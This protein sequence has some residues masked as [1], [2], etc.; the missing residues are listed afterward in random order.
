MTQ[1]IPNGKQQFTDNNG[2]PLLGGKV[3]F[4]QVGTQTPKNT[5]QDSAE[6]ILNTNPVTLDAR[7]SA[8][9][10]GTGPY[11]QVVRDMF[12]SLIWDQIIPDAAGSFI[13]D[14]G[15]HNDPNKGA[16]LI[17]R[18][19]RQ[20]FS[21]SELMTIPGRYH[22]DQI[23]LSSY[24]SSWAVPP[25]A[26]PLGAG[27]MVWDENSAETPDLG[28]VFQ[29]GSM[30]LGR[31]KRKAEEYVDVDYGI[32]GDGTDETLAWNR[33][34]SSIPDGASV[35]ITR[36]SKVGNLLCSKNSISL[37]ARSS[38]YIESPALISASASVSPLLLIGG[39]GWSISN[40]LFEDQSAASGSVNIGS[41]AV[42][43]LRSDLSRD[44]DSRINGC[45]FSSFD[46]GVHAVGI[47]LLALEN[48][49][50]LCLRPILV[51]QVGSE[52]VRGIR[53]V[54]NRF[55]GRPS[56]A[57]DYC[58]TIN[59][60]A[61]AETQVTGNLADGIGGFYKGH[62]SRRSSVSDNNIATPAADA[63]VFNG[64]SYGRSSDN[65]IGGGERSALVIDGCTSPTIDGLTIDTVYQSGIVIRNSQSWKIRNADIS[66]VNSRFST[67]GNV[68]DGILIENTCSVGVLDSC[69]IRQLNAT[70]GR[71]GVS[72]FGNQT[73]FLGNCAV[74]NFAVGNFNQGTLQRVYGD[75]GVQ[76]SRRRMEY[77]AAIPSTGIWGI[78][79]IVW[80]TSPTASGFIGWVCTTAGTPGTWKTFGAISA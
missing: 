55:H 52:T 29:V 74:V 17:G 30:P 71:Y 50:S 33:L 58:I 67:D 8:S 40:V 51:D 44:V 65:I 10:Y 42:K 38:A 27:I 34:L 68:Y 70:S 56:G 72:N 53:V 66:N 41:V 39:Y 25:K 76:S 15:D 59:G 73:L 6:T 63:I 22:G 13:A 46:I 78:G 43:F 54:N 3:Y 79:D 57:L 35:V 23:I 4:Y 75:T 20:V 14:L 26:E 64:G 16:G 7:G 31:W 24:Y 80:H 21:V 32:T 36:R 11:R 77:A 28:R 18:A 37:T 1:L 49:F 62:L 2:R 61:Q 19:T 45:N 69:F 48:I 12:G 47:N 5:Y 60:T 9:I